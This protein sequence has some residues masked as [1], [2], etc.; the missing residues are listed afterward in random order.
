MKKWFAVIPVFVLLSF[1][2][3]SI[4]AQRKTPRRAAPPYLDRY[5]NG[6][7]PVGP[8]VELEHGGSLPPTLKGRRVTNSPL[9]FERGAVD[10]ADERVRSLR[11]AALG[12]SRV[13]QALGQRF[14]FITAGAT[15]LAKEQRPPTNN[16]LT[17]LRFFSYSNNRAY[18]V[19][20]SGEEV[21]RVIPKRRGYQPPASREEVE[22]AAEI[23]KKDARF[24]NDLAGLFVRGILTPSENSN[25]HLYLLFYRGRGLERGRPVFEATV[26]MT[27]ERVVNARRVRQ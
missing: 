17:T 25:R 15:E 7:P 3:G 14:T 5:R 27:A 12:D 22:A 21:V 11:Q 19:R 13:R 10:L 24:R 16:P 26:D 8:T 1:F 23:V 2:S 18:E 6:L 4:Y 9:E 20:M